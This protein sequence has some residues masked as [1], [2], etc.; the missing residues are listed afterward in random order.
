MQV[1]L[2]MDEMKEQLKSAS[3]EYLKTDLLQVTW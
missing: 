3:S 2:Y 1:Y